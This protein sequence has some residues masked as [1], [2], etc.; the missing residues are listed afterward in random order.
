MAYCNNNDI[1]EYKEV[2]KVKLS[3]H[4]NF[5]IKIIKPYPKNEPWIIY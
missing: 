2:K 4:K 5:T 1:Y 3:T